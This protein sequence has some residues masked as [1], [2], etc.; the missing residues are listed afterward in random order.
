MPREGRRSNDTV[1][2]ELERLILS[3][4]L[5]PGEHV[6]EQMLADRLKV[7][8]APVRE[9]C[10]ALEGAG[11]LRRVPNRGVFV[12]D[13]GL[14]SATDVFDI[15]AELAGIVG[16]EAV[17]NASERVLDELKAMIATMD[18][19][20]AALLVDQYAALNLQF[21]E[22]LY[23]LAS[24]RRVA[25]LDRALGR[26]MLIYRRRGLASGG[27]LEHSN[28]EHRRIFEA[29]RRGRGDELAAVLRQHILNGKHRFLRA[30]GSDPQAGAQAPDAAPR[31]KARRRAQADRKRA[32]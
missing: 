8:R 26:E 3:G 29:L 11:L 31:T 25:E 5:A 16:R 17:H 4:E 28:A 12:R 7:G 20:A 32:A 19:A 9:A 18:T 27:G 13:V 23:S 10:R 30:M 21:H 6:K 1:Q 15:R 2:Y 14:S 22:R 24:N